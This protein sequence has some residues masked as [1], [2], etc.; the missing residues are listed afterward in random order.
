MRLSGV[1]RFS[2]PSAPR[3]MQ[4]AT[5]VR[6]QPGCFAANSSISFLKSARPRMGSLHS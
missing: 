5:D 3:S 4:L 1:A 6:R 2:A